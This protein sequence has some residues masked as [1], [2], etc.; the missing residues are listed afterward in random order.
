MSVKLITG[1][2]ITVATG[3][4]EQRIIA[5]AKSNVVAVYLSAPS[6]NTGHVYIGDADVAVGR[7][8]EV[9]KGTMVKIEAA[10]AGQLDMHEMYVDAATNGD[11]LNVAYLQKV[12]R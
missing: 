10:D 3:G 1:A 7:G 5:A 12:S 6:T 4:T 11:K 9:P 8:I 2:Q